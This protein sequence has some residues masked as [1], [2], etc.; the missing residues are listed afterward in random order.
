MGHGYFEGAPKIR[1]KT[2]RE[3]VGAVATSIRSETTLPQTNER[4][5]A[6]GPGG[7]GC[8]LS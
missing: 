3:G 5:E 7:P 8:V 4:V 1:Q 6:G 2:W